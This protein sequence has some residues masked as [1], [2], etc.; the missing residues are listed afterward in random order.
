MRERFLFPG[1]VF[2]LFL[3]AFPYPA[4]AGVPT[5]QLRNTTEKILKIVTD[6]ALKGEDKAEERRKLIRKAVDERFDRE[7]LS[8]RALG[9]QWASRNEKERKEFVTLFSELLERTYL[10]RV[11]GYSGEQVSYVGEK[12]EGEYATV[13]ARVLTAQRTEIPVLYRLRLKGDEWM[14]YDISI[15]GVSLVGNYRSQFQSILARSPYEE[16]VR[17]LKE[18]IAEK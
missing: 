14:V 4:F 9:R 10:E 13:E 12:V 1:L 18:Q 17:R 6:P 2:F 11:E 16:L 8:R 7:E 15:E 3:G 5:E